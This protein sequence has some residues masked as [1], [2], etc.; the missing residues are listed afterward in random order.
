MSSGHSR[1]F[2]NLVGAALGVSRT[3]YQNDADFENVLL[4]LLKNHD[5]VTGAVGTGTLTS[6]GTAPADGD[7]VTIGSVT[8]RFKTTPA[9]AYDVAIGASAAVALDNLKAAVNGT[10]TPGTEYYAGTQAHPLVTATTN[11]DTTQVFDS[12]F[13]AITNS[14]ATTETSGQ[15]SFGGATLASGLPGM[16]AP[17]AA[18]VAAVSG[19]RPLV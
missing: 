16:V 10:G 18:D 2:L 14:I 15:L 1:A 17:N 8:Y 5:T 4:Y 11:T 13:K 3:A 12:R 19:G 7:T 6:T 9:Q